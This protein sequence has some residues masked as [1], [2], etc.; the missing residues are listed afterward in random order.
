MNTNNED[1][2]FSELTKAMDMNAMEKMETASKPIINYRLPPP[3]PSSSLFPGVEELNYKYL[4]NIVNNT[5]TTARE[6]IEQIIEQIESRAG[7]QI[8]STKVKEE[9]EKQLLFCNTVLNYV[10]NFFNELT[11]DDYDSVLFD[12][13]LADIKNIDVNL[14]FFVAMLMYII[15][16]EISKNIKPDRDINMCRN[17]NTMKNCVRTYKLEDIVEHKNIQVF[18]KFMKALLYASG[19][20]GLR[21]LI[22]NDTTVSRKPESGG[23]RKTRRNKKSNRKTKKKQFLY[24]PNDPK[25]SFDV[26][27]DKNPKDT[28]PIKYTT[29]EDVKNTIHNLEDL[30][31]KGKYS[32]K[33]IW[34]VGMIQKVRLEAMLKNKNKLYPHAKNV[35]KRF[36]LANKYFLF[37]K[38]RS[39]ETDET[40]RKK[41]TFK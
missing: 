31:K 21:M 24:H 40:K 13:N 36:D 41:M 15:K 12:E 18:E 37:L 9:K 26:Y 39:K 27:I 2:Y 30:Y 1:R 19:K 10:D 35:K 38:S 16:E 25:K 11:K 29:I 4:I 20:E 5:I 3:P 34:Q 23:R 28:I 17:E 7:E 32:H 14:H 6:Q 22:L 33:R 8:D